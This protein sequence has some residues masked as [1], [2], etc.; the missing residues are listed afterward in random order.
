[1]VENRVKL[2]LRNGTP[3]FGLWI[4]LPCPS[5]VEV[6]ASYG[7]D[8][9]LIDTEH[10]PATPETTENMIR[11]AER[12]GVVPITR[13]AANDPALI[14]QALDRGALGVL[15]PL[16]NSAAEARAAVRAAKYPPEGIRG[17]AG[18]R[19]NRFGLDLPQYFA[20]WNDQVLV[21]CQVETADA[22]E[23]VEEIAAVPG[24]DVLF[25]G[26]NDLSANLKV[27]RQFDHPAFTSAVQRIQRA[28]QAHG[29][30]VGYMAAGA[31][32]A[33]ACAARGFLF[34]GAGSDARLLGGAAATL[35]GA[36]R[37]GIAAPARP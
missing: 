10:G 1:M 35:I 2:Q 26:P 13:V 37:A 20:A 9:L 4:S 30:A 5:G 33:L 24:L 21:A 12:H 22:L 29:V 3:T 25:I 14:K 31:D 36:I 11:A 6:L 15:V 23:Q 8:W 16:V 34:I 32:E 18:T 7:W 28:A 17:V 19:A 27:F